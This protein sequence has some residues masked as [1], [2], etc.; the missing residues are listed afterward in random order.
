MTSCAMIGGML[1]MAVG[2]GDGGEQWPHL[3]GR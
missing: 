1:P 2:L 3:D